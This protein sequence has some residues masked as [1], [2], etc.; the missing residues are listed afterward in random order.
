MYD[1]QD[2]SQIFNVKLNG[3]ILPWVNTAKQLGNYLSSK[4]NFSFQIPETKTDFICQRTILFDNVH[5][6][7]QQFGFY[8]PRLVVKLLSI[9]S[10]ALYGSSLWQ[11]TS[12]EHLNLNRS[13]NIALKIIRDLPH[14][15]HTRYLE[16]F[17][18]VPHLEAVLMGRYMGFIDNLAKSKKSLLRLIFNSCSS[19]Q[20]SLPARIWHS[21]CTSMEKFLLKN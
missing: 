13:W 20:I 15:T 21:S 17:S 16:S 4:L 5:Q 8:H 18:P 2:S 9:Y 11:L 7:Q 10:T 19:Y 3:D 12:D 1:D 6:I 14:P